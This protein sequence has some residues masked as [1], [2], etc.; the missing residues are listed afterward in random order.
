MAPEIQGRVFA[1]FASA[2]GAVAPVGLAIAAPVAG[3]TGVRSWHAT[4]GAMCVAMGV[5]DF[6][7]PSIRG[8]R[9]RPDAQSSAASA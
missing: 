4:A 7:V 2:S 3:W 5:A 1:L 9:G 8:L 6:F